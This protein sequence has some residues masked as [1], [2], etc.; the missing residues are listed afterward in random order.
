[1]TPV[2]GGAGASPVG[3]LQVCPKIVGKKVTETW[4]RGQSLSAAQPGNRAPDT[5]ATEANRNWSNLRC[6][7]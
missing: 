1:L 6:S 7:M 3:V 4:G 5:A 2:S